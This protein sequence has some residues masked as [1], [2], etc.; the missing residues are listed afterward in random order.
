MRDIFRAEASR[1]TGIVIALASNI[2]KMLSE[3]LEE[4]KEQRTSCPDLIIH[5][6]ISETLAGMTR[7]CRKSV[8]FETRV[9]V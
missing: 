8:E 7:I 1:V 9:Q 4:T 2:A 6:P 5:S 3:V